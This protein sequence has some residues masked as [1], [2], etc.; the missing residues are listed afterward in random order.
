MDGMNPRNGC[1]KEKKYCWMIA[2]QTGTPDD[3]KSTGETQ[4]QSWIERGGDDYIT[5]VT[6]HKDI[7]R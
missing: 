6:I 7:H 2:L 3:G 4:R 1:Q 5:P